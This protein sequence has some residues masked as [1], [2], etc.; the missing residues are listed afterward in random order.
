VGRTHLTVESLELAGCGTNMSGSRVIRIGWMW[1][2]HI[3][4]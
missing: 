2:E 3:W 4:Q 1:D